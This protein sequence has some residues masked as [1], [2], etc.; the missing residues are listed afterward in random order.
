V[1]LL[2]TATYEALTTSSSFECHF[3]FTEHKALSVYTITYTSLH[4][5]ILVSPLFGLSFKLLLLSAS[6]TAYLT[7]SLMLFP[8]AHLVHLVCKHLDVGI[9]FE[10]LLKG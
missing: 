4:L 3:Y 1:N 8:Q 2:L 9:F 5:L 6:E 10:I 7:V